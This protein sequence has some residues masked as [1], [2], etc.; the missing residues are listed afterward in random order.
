MKYAEKITEEIKDV[1]Y[2][3]KVD[4]M[5]KIV[6]D[7]LQSTRI[8]VAGQGRSGFMMKSFAMRLMHIGFEANVVGETVTPSIK[9]GD[10]LIIGSGSGE[11]ES[12]VAMSL[13][14]KE[15][16]AKVAVVTTNANSTIA[17]QAETIVKLKAQA[18]GDESSTSTI[19]PMGSLFEQCL[20]ICLDSVILI[21]MDEKKKDGNIMF[22]R[23][24]NIE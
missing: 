19:Q 18:K 15:L 21:L 8:F 20:L 24:A 13:K 9:K 22:T 10:L 1:V 6:A 4:Q 5:Q 12:L 23:H 3:I 16:G 14:T 2:Q 7:I 11:T 17:K